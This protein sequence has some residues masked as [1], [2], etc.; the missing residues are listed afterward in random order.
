M[1]ELGRGHIFGTVAA[2][3]GFPTEAEISSDF[4]HVRDWL[5]GN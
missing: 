4:L 3:D 5:A 1:P 2:G